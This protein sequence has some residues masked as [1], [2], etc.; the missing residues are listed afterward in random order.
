MVRDLLQYR[1]P[2]GRGVRVV[3][4]TA[5]EKDAV[6]LDAA[7]QVG[8]DASVADFRVTEIHYGVSRMIKQVSDK[9]Y[10]TMEALL[11][12]DVK[13]K[14]TDPGDLEDNYDK[15][16]TAKDDAVLS[17]IYRKLHEVS[18]DEIEAIAGKALPISV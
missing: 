13:W 3:E 8:K 7:K 17:A 12:P 9:K 10:D 1:L 16:F 2:S 6:T 5:T 14:D 18:A 11:A 4:L 15:Y